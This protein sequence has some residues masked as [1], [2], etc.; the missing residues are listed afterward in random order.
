[1][2]VAE[3]APT[4]AQTITQQNVAPLMHMLNLRVRLSTIYKIQNLTTE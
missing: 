3:R 2:A 4:I 1:M